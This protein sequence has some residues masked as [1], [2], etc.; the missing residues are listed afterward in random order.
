[1]DL[2]SLI[3]EGSLSEA[4]TALVEGVKSSPADTGLRTLLFQVLALLGEWDKASIHLDMISTQDPSRLTGVSV[5]SQIVAAEKERAEVFGLKQVP[6]LLPETP[7]FFEPFYRAARALLAG[8]PGADGLFAQAEE[9]VPTVKGT[10]DGEPFSGF[11]DTDSVLSPFIEAF[12][13][14]R[15]VWIPVAAVRELTVAEPRTLTDL[16]WIQANVTTWEG[17]T[18]GCFLPVLYPGSASHENDEVK[19]GR[20]TDWQDLGNGCCR[21][22]GQHVYQAGEKETALLEIREVIFTYGGK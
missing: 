7:D 18:V 14:G 13:H 9:L 19:R 11:Q 5:F 20:M 17:L 12:V 4:R 15:Y 16:I 6:S 22:A 21:G 8:D 1:M 3:K 2:R 10:I